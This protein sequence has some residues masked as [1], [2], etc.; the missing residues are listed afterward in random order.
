MRTEP[1]SARAVAAAPDPVRCWHRVQWQ[2]EAE[3]NG[4]STSNRTVPQPHLPVSAVIV[5]RV[6]EAAGLQGKRALE[7]CDGTPERAVDAASN[8]HPV[9]ETLQARSRLVLDHEA[10]PKT[11]SV[12]LEMALVPSVGQSVLRAVVLDKTVRLE[13][14]KH[15]PELDLPAEQLDDDP[16]L[17]TRCS[18]PGL[19]RD[20]DD[21]R[22]VRQPVRGVR[23]VLEARRERDV[24]AMLTRDPHSP[25]RR[26]STET[27]PRSPVV[28][29]GALGAGGTS[30]RTPCA[31]TPIA[32]VSRVWAADGPSWP[33]HAPSA[34]GSRALPSSPVDSAPTSTPSAS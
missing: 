28:P 27:A 30:C 7:I 16:R 5:S 33:A 20:P 8:E 4:R 23:D 10:V 22:P 21:S 34:D 2:Y 29:V 1:D 14:P 32:P 12:G 25:P 17:V 26:P 18:P 15:H 11:A 31:A 24:E 6:L 13:P 3:R 19:R 9:V